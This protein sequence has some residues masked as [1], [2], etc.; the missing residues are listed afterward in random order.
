MKNFFKIQ[1]ISMWMIFGLMI[2]RFMAGFGLIQCMDMF[3][4]EHESAK[5]NTGGMTQTFYFAIAEDIETWPTYTP[6]VT[7]TTPEELMNYTGDFVMKT[8]KRFFKGYCTHGTGE[9]KFDAIGP[10]DGKSFKHSI[11]FFRPGMDA[12]ALAWL[13]LNKN[14]NLVFL[15]YDKDDTLLTVGSEKM[16]AKFESGAGT[17]GKSGEDSKGATVTFFSELASPPKAYT[18]TIPLTEAV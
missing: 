6:K 15:G 16:S 4:I 10:I 2:E 13:D 5:D 8:G 3:D 18:G 17:T 7:A 11:E 14:A 1:F 9:V 12:K